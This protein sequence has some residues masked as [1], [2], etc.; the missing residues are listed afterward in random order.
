ML[1]SNL[2]HQQTRCIGAIDMNKKI[3]KNYCFELDNFERGINKRLQIIVSDYD[4]K[5]AKN[6][7]AKMLG[8]IVFDKMT[9]AWSEKED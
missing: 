9:L 7:V 6:Q 1:G 5:N 4:L 2:D 8:K 3:L